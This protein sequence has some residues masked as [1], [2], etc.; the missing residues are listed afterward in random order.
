VE[1]L[2]VFVIGAGLGIGARYLVPGRNTYGIMIAPAVGASTAAIVWSL[3]TWAGWTFDGGW[4]WVV[5]LG[6]ALIVSVVAELL[7]ARWRRDHDAQL[8][9]QLSGGRA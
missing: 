1:L 5:S 9:R 8:L 6:A 3:L 2:F 7:L 4:I